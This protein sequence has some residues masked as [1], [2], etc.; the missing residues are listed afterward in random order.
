MGGIYEELE[1]LFGD[2][3]GEGMTTLDMMRLPSSTR[4]VVQ[5]MLRNRAEMTYSALCEAIGKMP[6]DKRLSRAELDE[7]LDAMSRLGLL[8]R[9]E[10]RKAV[11]YKL[12]LGHT[13]GGT[14]PPPKPGEEASQARTRSEE[15]WDALGSDELDDSGGGGSFFGRLLGRRGSKSKPGE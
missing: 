11:T 13:A 10:H 2:R 9:T 4:I 7:V 15:V 14:H 12:N 1:R 6:K 8:V 3:G 5:L